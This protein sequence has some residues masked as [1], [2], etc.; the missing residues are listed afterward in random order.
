[1]KTLIETKNRY[2]ERRRK[3]RPRNNDLASRLKSP[4]AINDF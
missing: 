4:L 3:S 1:M 2:V